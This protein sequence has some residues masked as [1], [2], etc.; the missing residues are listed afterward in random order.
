MI[1]GMCRYAFKLQIFK[2]TVVP[3]VTMNVQKIFLLSDG[4]ETSQER[5]LGCVEVHSGFENFSM[6]S[7]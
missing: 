6:G 4:K 7:H 5:Y 3:M 1:L 2:I